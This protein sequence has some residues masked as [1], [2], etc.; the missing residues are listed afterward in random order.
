VLRVPLNFYLTVARGVR[1]TCKQAAVTLL[2]AGRGWEVWLAWRRRHQVLSAW[3]HHR[4]R[5]ARNEQILLV[6]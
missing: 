3:Y 2:G 4:T 5:L 1:L 6:S